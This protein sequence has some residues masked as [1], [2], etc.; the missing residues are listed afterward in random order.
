MNSI[1]YGL[2][3]TPTPTR[4][5]LHRILVAAVES[6]DPCSSAHRFLIT[7]SSPRSLASASTLD[8]LAA[9]T[10]GVRCADVDHCDTH[11]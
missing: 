3:R 4:E 5:E 8:Q 9:G 7:S 6:Q 2:R 10:D 11:P 1:K